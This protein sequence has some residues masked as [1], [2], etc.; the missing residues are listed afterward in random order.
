VPGNKDGRLRSLLAVDEA[1]VTIAAALGPEQTGRALWLVL[2]DNGFLLGEHGMRGKGVWWDQA[3]RV[4]LLAGGP[5]L[6]S[7]EDR[8]L[9]ATIDVAPTIARAAGVPLPVV[10][11]GRALQDAWNRE[12]VLVEGWPNADEPGVPWAGVKTIDGLYLERRGDPPV[13]YALADGEAKPH[14]LRNADAWTALLAALRDC[15]GQ[16]C[17]DADGGG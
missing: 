8:R 13:L 4:S 11:D 12:R 9:A 1:V 15:A 2:S 7:G 3:V 17:R 16:A 5:G 6:G 14:P 10:P